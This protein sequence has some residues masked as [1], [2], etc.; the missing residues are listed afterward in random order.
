M[1][2]YVFLVL[3][4]AAEASFWPFTLI[5]SGESDEPEESEEPSEGLSRNNPSTNNLDRNN[6]DDDDDDGDDDERLA[7]LLANHFLRQLRDQAIS[8]NLDLADNKEFQYHQQPEQEDNSNHHYQ[9]SEPADN[10][11]NHH[12]Q[13]AAP[14]GPEHHQYQPATPTT[15][16]PY[17][18]KSTPPKVDPYHH[19]STPPIV[20]PYHHQS[21]PPTVDLYHHQPTT[22]PKP[23]SY[24][25]QPIPTIYSYPKLITNG[26]IKPAKPGQSVNHY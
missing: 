6:P 2:Y 12:H 16:D 25:N 22:T 5:S 9:P 3:I 10:S 24:S 13:P 19:Q 18:H 15:V 20:E 23:S 17:H 1:K 21:T 11:N 14:S 8:M 4:I 26:I 7:R